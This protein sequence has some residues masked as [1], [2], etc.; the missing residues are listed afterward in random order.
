[1][2]TEEARAVAEDARHATIESVAAT[3]DSLHCTLEQMKFL[4][5]ARQT[6]RDLKDMRPP[7]RIH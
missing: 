3:A 7:D 5:E 4:E 2:A 6:V 1:V